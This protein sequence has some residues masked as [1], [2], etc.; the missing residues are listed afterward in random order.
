MDEMPGPEAWLALHGGETHDAVT[1]PLVGHLED[2][3]SCP[4]RLL[5]MKPGEPVPNLWIQVGQ[6][7]AKL[8]LDNAEI[9][10]MRPVPARRKP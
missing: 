4:D 8:A 7:G 10:R 3:R 6:P 9:V 2:C 5:R 1:E